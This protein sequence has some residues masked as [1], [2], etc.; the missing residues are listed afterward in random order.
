MHNYIYDLFWIYII[1][2]YTIMENWDKVNREKTG[3]YLNQIIKDILQ[4]IEENRRILAPTFL[5]W[6]QNKSPQE[7]N[8]IVKLLNERFY[9]SSDDNIKR[10]IGTAI[11]MIK[12]IIEEQEWFSDVWDKIVNEI[13]EKII[14]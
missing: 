9:E 14:L 10:N 8:L 7:L 6:I 11:V 2:Y 13:K 4:E 3:E 5:S 1:F 12:G